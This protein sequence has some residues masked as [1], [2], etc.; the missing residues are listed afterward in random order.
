MAGEF[1]QKRDDV[2][3]FCTLP[4][5]HSPRPCVFVGPAHRASLPDVLERGGYVPVSELKAA[6]ERM[7]R[8][9]EKGRRKECD[10]GSSA[11][12]EPTPGG[13]SPP[14][15][16]SYAT[17][18]GCGRQGVV[19]AGHRCSDKRGS[20][21]LASPTPA[22]MLGEAFSL[23]NRAIGQMEHVEAALGV[24]DVTNLRRALSHT[25]EAATL[26]DWSRR[27]AEAR[28]G[29]RT[30]PSGPAQPALDALRR[31]Q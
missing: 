7:Q 22:T 12:H 16:P 3:R 29:R 2:G 9:A 18:P 13:C 1:C 20:Q 15:A 25:R 19:G 8:E 11:P 27:E 28:D 4:D 30:T 24:G 6:A 14:R 23:L 26:A 10:C 21:P 17:C 31:G 5:K